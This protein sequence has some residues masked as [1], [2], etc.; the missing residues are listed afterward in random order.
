MPPHLLSRRAVCV[1]ARARVCVRACVCVLRMHPP[2]QGTVDWRL[3]LS[4]WLRLPVVSSQPLHDQNEVLLQ[5]QQRQQRASPQ[6]LGLQA[7]V[8][9]RD[10]VG[11][12]RRAITASQR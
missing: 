11:C 5:Q 9:A 10:Q 12:Y 2:S 1:C 7:G 8:G 6:S 3:M 4:V